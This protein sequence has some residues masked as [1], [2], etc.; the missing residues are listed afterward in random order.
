MRDEE[1]PQCRWVAVVDA[2]G[3]RRLE[4]RWHVPVVPAPAQLVATQ[5]VAPRVA[6]AA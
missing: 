4:M 1:F 6:R 5:P 2:D 3:R